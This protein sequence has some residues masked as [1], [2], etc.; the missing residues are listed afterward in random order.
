MFDLY[1]NERLAEWK[2]FRDYLE[3]SS[4]PLQD[5]AKFWSKAPLVNCFLDHKNSQSWPDPWH[6]VLDNR[7][8]DLAIVLGMLYTIKLTQ[9]FMDSVCEIHM[10]IP[11]NDLEFILVVD[12]KTFLNLVYGESVDKDSVENFEPNMIWSTAIPL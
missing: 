6:L 7:Y 12:N 1:G 2:K 8:D 3:I 11:K 10:S 4:N 9:R 5:T